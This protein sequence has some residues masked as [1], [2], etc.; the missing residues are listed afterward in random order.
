MA[1]AVLPLEDG[2]KPINKK[3]PDRFRTFSP[4]FA[5]FRPF[6]HFFALFVSDLSKKMLSRK[7]CPEFVGPK[8]N[9]RLKD[10]SPNSSRDLSMLEA[11]KR[12]QPEGDGQDFVTTSRAVVMTF[13]MLYD[14]L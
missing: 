7:P 9:N 4:L 1:T 14:V 11:S 2:P 6:S 3:H 5:C 8:P 10:C 12:E 13:V